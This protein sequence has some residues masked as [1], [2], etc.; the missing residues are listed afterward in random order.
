MKPISEHTIGEVWG[1]FMGGS[2]HLA[3]PITRDESGIAS[4]S[5]RNYISTS[6]RVGRVICYCGQF[7]KPTLS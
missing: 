1:Y 3:S 4:S 7:N 5:H 2:A 6:Y